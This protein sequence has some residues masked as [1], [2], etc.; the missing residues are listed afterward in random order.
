MRPGPGLR[1]RRRERVRHSPGP[2]RRALGVVFSI[3]LVR[4]PRLVARA[5]RRALYARLRARARRARRRRLPDLPRAVRHRGDLRLVRDLRSHGRRRLDLAAS[6]RCA[7]EL[8]SDGTHRAA[9]RHRPHRRYGRTTG[10]IGPGAS[11]PQPNDTWRT[12][13]INLLRGKGTRGVKGAEALDPAIGEPDASVF[14]CPVCQRPLSHGTARCP[15]C[16][17]SG[18]IMGLR[19]TQ[20]G[21]ILALG[22]A[23]GVALGVAL[24]AILISMSIREPSVAAAAVPTEAPAAISSAA[25]VAVGPGGV[26]GGGLPTIAMAALS[27]GTAVVDGRIRSTRQ[28]SGRRSRHGPRHRHRARPRLLAAD[29]ALGSDLTGRL[30]RWPDAG[31]VAIPARRLLPIDGEDGAGRAA[32][33]A[34]RQRLLPID[35]RRDAQG[36]HR[37]RAVDAASR[38]LA[39]TVGLELPPVDQPAP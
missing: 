26:S 5:D 22:V 1:D 34:V 30:A 4:L 33:L 24:T 21:G 37:P 17:S 20:A 28:R 18:L 2:S 38:T 23:I 13:T 12:M 11:G 25:P 36:A 10:T 6:W 3:A 31:P 39:G 15:A 8:T 35:R 27:R 14:N 29:A 16:G 9:V 19:M 32:L 7:V